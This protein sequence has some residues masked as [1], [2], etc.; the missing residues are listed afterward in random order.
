[1]AEL[2]LESHDG[3]FIGILPL[4]QVNLRLRHITLDTPHLW[5]AFGIAEEPITQYHAQL[6]I[7]RSRCL[8]L[9][10]RVNALGSSDSAK[11]CLSLDDILQPVAARVRSLDTCLDTYQDLSVVKEVLMKL[12]LPLLEDINLDYDSVFFDGPDRTITLADGG[13]SLRTLGL[14]GVLLLNP[15][16]QS[17][18]SLT[19]GN[20]AC[21]RWRESAIS[22][23]VALA[24]SLETLTL[25]GMEGTFDTTKDL[26]K[27]NLQC[28]S[29]RRLSLLDIASICIYRVLLSL[30][31]P[32][33]K[34]VH[35]TTPSTDYEAKTGSQVHWKRATDYFKEVYGV[36][37]SPFNKVHSL[38]IDKSED[39]FGARHQQ[40]FF[41]FLMTTFPCIHS[42]GIDAEEIVALKISNGNDPDSPRF[43]GWA[44]LQELTVNGLP[45][46]STFKRILEFAR[47]RNGTALLGQD[48]GD[49]EEEKAAMDKSVEGSDDQLAG[50]WNNAEI[51]AQEDQNRDIDGAMLE[52]KFEDIPPFLKIKKVSARRSRTEDGAVDRLIQLLKTA[53][54]V[55][56][57]TYRVQDLETNVGVVSA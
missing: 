37:T 28:P 39:G 13:A 8:P 26:P 11:L 6:C 5:T 48:L 25:V 18:K 42:L 14:T 38:V 30:H 4:S 29:L 1:M 21:W 12:S 55:V 19:L 35:I 3:F 43:G 54:D 44:F 23:L 57:V 15:N 53:V 17:L 2:C 16:L 27:F 45:S 36:A 10:V 34:Y 40:G 33:L 51:K 56:D 9:S 22:G 49:D 31:S 24:S 41:R 46:R 52:D 32:L 20:G 50:S 7:E 47:I